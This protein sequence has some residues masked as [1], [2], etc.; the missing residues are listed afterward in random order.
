LRE[1]NENLRRAQEREKNRILK[2]LD[3][4]IRASEQM[5]EKGRD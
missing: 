1:L 2:E 4:V 5:K 3:K